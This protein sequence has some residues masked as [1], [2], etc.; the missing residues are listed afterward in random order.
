MIR[1]KFLYDL[2]PVIDQ[3]QRDLLPF[4]QNR[5]AF[6]DELLVRKNEL[7]LPVWLYYFASRAGRRGIA[8]LRLL[9]RPACL[10][11]NVPRGSGSGSAGVADVTVKVAMACGL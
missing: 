3:V 11:L 9:Q 5:S 4:G 2:Q 10:L 6:F 7:Q 8:A 1:G